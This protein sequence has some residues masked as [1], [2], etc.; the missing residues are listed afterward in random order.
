LLKENGAVLIG[1][2]AF[3]SR[4][5]LEHCQKEAGEEWDKD[6]IYFVFD[7]LKQTFPE[8]K[9]EQISFCAGLLSLT[10]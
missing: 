10:R 6:E 1:D 8:L 4:D 2:V 3:R 9:F 5:E 7:E